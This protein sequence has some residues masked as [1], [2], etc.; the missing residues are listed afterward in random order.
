[1]SGFKLD[2][3]SD[4]NLMP[5]RMYKMLFPQTSNVNELMKYQGNIQRP[6]TELL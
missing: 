4:G 5:I 6:S 3:G 1:M 2:A